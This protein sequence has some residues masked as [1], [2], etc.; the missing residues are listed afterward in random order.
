MGRHEPD[1]IP[2]VDKIRD[3][4]PMKRIRN[5]RPTEPIP[6]AEHKRRSW[7]LALL[8]SG[9]VTAAIAIPVVVGSLTA[10]ESPQRPRSAVS[11][12]YSPEP[13][14]VPTVTVT[15]NQIRYRTR[16]PK[17]APTVTRTIHQTSAPKMIPTIVPGPRTT[18]T[19]TI[20]PKPVPAVTETEY[21]DRCFRV[22]NNVIIGEIPCP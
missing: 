21:L 2:L 12:I 6:S 14:P 11:G 17:P 19:K 5:D 7:P 22:R 15:K 16:D 18:I 13:E 10:E 8:L 20:R 4:G 1:P 9:V 3:S